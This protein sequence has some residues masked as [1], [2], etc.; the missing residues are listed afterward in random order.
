[1]PM[2]CA[3]G[4]EGGGEIGIHS[5]DPLSIPPGKDALVRRALGR[6]LLWMR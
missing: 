5:K 2:S 1:M 4:E 3:A 6:Q